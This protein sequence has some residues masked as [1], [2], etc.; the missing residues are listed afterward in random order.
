[1]PEQ[2]M[3]DKKL[4]SMVPGKLSIWRHR[5][6]W[7]FEVTED[8]WL[9]ERMYVDLMSSSPPSPPLKTK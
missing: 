3:N 1:M 7:K 4:V 8:R 2:G 5:V 6:L 9:V